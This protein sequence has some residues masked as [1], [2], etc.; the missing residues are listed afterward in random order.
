MSHLADRVTALVDG[1]LSHDERD[2]ALAHVTGCAECRD[3]LELQ[4]RLKA[5]VVGLADPPLSSALNHRLLAVAAVPQAEA[6]AAERRAPIRQP[7]T[8][9]AT[10]RPHRASSPRRATFLGG[11]LLGVGGL[12]VGTAMI[13]PPADGGTRPAAAPPPASFSGVSPDARSSPLPV[14]GAGSSVA[15]TNVL[16][17]Q[18]LAVQQSVRAAPP[19]L[20]PAP[21]LPLGRAVH[22]AEFRPPAGR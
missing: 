5:A 4:R 6:P 20:T 2:R 1:E 17:M 8:H 7:Y 19:R 16:G 15:S 14:G 11:A 12:A 13:L 18:A 9:P 22:T 10:A 21:A 3:E